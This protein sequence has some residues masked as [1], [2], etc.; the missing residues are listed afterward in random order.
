MSAHLEEEDEAVGL[1]CQCLHHGL[2]G[3]RGVL[4]LSLLGLRRT[5][6]HMFSSQKQLC[7]KAGAESLV[8]EFSFIRA[9]DSP[10]SHA[11]FGAKSSWCSQAL[12]LELQY[13]LGLE[14][15]SSQLSRATG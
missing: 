1:A 10:C 14:H 9:T 13:C 15:P 2:D 3:L 7:Y 11:F 6:S 4:R 5:Q 12:Q 8:S